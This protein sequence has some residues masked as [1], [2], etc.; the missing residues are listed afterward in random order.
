MTHAIEQRQLGRSDLRVSALSLGSWLT[1][2]RLPRE[3]G[4]AIMRTAQEHGITFLDDARYNDPTGRAPIPT[5]YSEVIFG[6]LFRFVQRDVRRG[7]Y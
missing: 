2:E 5:G 3:M 7:Q 6:E 4:L 1:F